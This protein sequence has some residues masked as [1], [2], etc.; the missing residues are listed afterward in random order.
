MKSKLT[1]ALAVAALLSLP[2]YAADTQPPSTQ[3]ATSAASQ[4]A[5]KP[6]TQPDK[7]KGILPIP[8]YSGDLLQRSYLTGDW[9]GARSKLANKGITLDFNFTQVAQS[10]VK[11]GRDNDTDYGGS[12]DYLFK[13]DLQQMGAVPGGIFTFRAETRYGESVNNDTG[14]ILPVDTRGLFPLTDRPNDTIPITVTELNYTQFLSPHFGVFIGKLQTL[15]G[16]PNEFSSGRGRSQFMNSNFIFNS[17][18]ALTTPYSTLGAGGI[19]LP[20]ENISVSTSF[21]NTKDSSTTS[22]FE[23]LNN[24][25]TWNTEADFQYRLGKLPGGVNVGVNYAFAGDFSQIDGTLSLIRGTG[26]TLPH[27]SDSWAL[28]TS[29]WQYLYTPDDTS[30]HINHRDGKPDLRGIGV[31]GRLGYGDPSTNPVHWSTSIGLGG[32]GMIPTRDQDTFG[33]SYVYTALQNNRDYTVLNISEYTQGTEAYYNI[34]FTPAVNLTFDV[35]WIEGGAQ[36]IPAAT[37][38]GMRLNLRF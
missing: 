23:N 38:L 28:Y 1:C 16:D 35:Q 2:A 26:L 9:Y 27:T 15:D 8:D 11:G 20:T 6:A 22:G 24:G 13:F 3:P 10:I 21:I 14:A 34:A 5:T 19:W 18:L 30:K 25:W 31:F 7:A 12:L 32:R 29:F 17:A 37:I 4:P 36:S 33:V